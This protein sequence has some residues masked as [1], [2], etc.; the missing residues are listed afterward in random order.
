MKVKAAGRLVHTFTT[1]ISRSHCLIALLFT[2][3]YHAKSYTQQL[4][5]CPLVAG[6]DAP[7]AVHEWLEPAHDAALELVVWRRE[8]IAARPAPAEI[9]H[10][11]VLVLVS[12]A[13]SVERYIF[14]QR[15]SGSHGL[16]FRRGPHGQS[17]VHS[18]H[19]V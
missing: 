2:V 3:P 19:R 12:A 17:H 16:R 7:L 13:A 8:G 11:A 9:V 5:L 1:F 10:E 18:T 4:Q 6:Y 15:A 14:E